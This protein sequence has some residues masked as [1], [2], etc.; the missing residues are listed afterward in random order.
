MKNKKEKVTRK[1][2]T[3]LLGLIIVII[4]II[5]IAP[6]IST[7]APLTMHNQNCK[8]SC[9]DIYSLVYAHNESISNLKYI[10]MDESL[11]Y[12]SEEAIKGLKLLHK[13]GCL[14][15]DESI[16][17]LKFSARCTNIK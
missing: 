8:V 12:Q 1:H 6:G 10:A 17:D 2:W 5:K 13:I 4:M 16:M 15:D 11:P 7:S 9:L 14:S 3:I